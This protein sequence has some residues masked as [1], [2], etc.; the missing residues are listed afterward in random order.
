MLKSMHL[1]VADQR[2]D[3]LEITGFSLIE[4]G[5]TFTKC[6][7]E[8]SMLKALEKG[9]DALIFDTNLVPFSSKGILR[10]I[11][12]SYQVPV[13]L[14]T[15]DEIAL[16][17]DLIL[18]S[19]ISLVQTKPLKTHELLKTLKLAVNQ[20]AAHCI[21]LTNYLSNAEATRFIELR[22]PAMIPPCIRTILKDFKSWG[23]VPHNE[24]FIELVWQEIMTNAIYH[25]HGYSG[26]KLA[27]ENIVLTGE[28]KV[29]V[30]YG[31]NQHQFG[32]SVLDNNG[33]LTRNKILQ[34][35]F[36]VMKQKQ[37]LEIAADSGEDV[38]EHI[39]EDGRGID[40]LRTFSGEFYIVI[41]PGKVTEI[42][43]LY[44]GSTLDETRTSINVFEL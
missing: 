43:I 11:K 26:E 36:K 4:G 13:I 5:H 44:D 32:I 29:V 17:I 3:Y 24:L 19:E 7:D 35:I 1:V 39:S 40:L 28:K 6:T 14:T 10:E 23:Y 42:I 27:A 15:V 33:T 16:H 9:C 20:S 38:T 21:G 8:A 37:A 25:S 30:E 18:D 41:D 2:E 34:S 12:K 31:Y 22:E